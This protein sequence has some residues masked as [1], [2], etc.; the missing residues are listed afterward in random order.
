[1]S[2]AD[3]S[4]LASGRRRINPRYILDG[5]GRPAGGVADLSFVDG[6]DLINELE[7]SITPI[8]TRPMPQRKLPPLKRVTV[9]RKI[10]AGYATPEQPL[11]GRGK[12]HASHE[13]RV[14]RGTWHA[15]IKV[16]VSTAIN[17]IPPRFWEG[18]LQMKELNATI[19]VVVAEM[20]GAR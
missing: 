15:E 3:R 18:F 7:R 9:A 5:P 19:N 12:L 10:R 1:M 4:Y 20:M 17:V 16:L 13:V 8:V 6:V 11:V 14:I 2:A